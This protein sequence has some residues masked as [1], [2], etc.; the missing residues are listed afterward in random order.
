MKVHI[1]N[2]SEST[3]H[4][5]ETILNTLH[6]HTNCV[7]FCSQSSNCWW[8]S[9]M[10]SI[11]IHPLS[12]NG[13]SSGQERG[14]I[15]FATYSSITSIDFKGPGWSLFLKINQNVFF[16]S[17]RRSIFSGTFY[18]LFCVYSVLI[19]LKFYHKGNI[20]V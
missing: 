19:R 10:Y 15:S 7:S 9:I 16:Y 12:E 1:F 6:V 5:G 2:S 20:W 18:Y 4:F 11:F 14:G 17:V 3:P 13:G 8:Q